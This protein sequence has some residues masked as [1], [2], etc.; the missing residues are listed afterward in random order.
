MCHIFSKWAIII[1]TQL[2]D[3]QNI[4]LIR[5]TS[6]KYHVNHGNGH[7]HILVDDHGQ[8]DQLTVQPM[9]GKK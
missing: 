5:W 7:S 1:M 4:M 9:A 3:A 2:G 6:F 8:W